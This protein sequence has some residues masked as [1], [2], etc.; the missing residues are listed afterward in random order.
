MRTNILKKN[1][2]EGKTSLGLSISS[3]AHPDLAEY[4]GYQGWD[5]VWM[6]VEHGSYTLADIA[7]IARACDVAGI[8]SMAR[9]GKP[10]SSS[11]LL[12]F[13]ETG[14]QGIV[15]PHVHSREDV[16]LMIEGAKY[17]PIGKRS[18]GA[19]RAG[20]FGVGMNAADAYQRANEESMTIA[21]VED[22]EGVENVDEIVSVPELD[23]LLVGPGDLA[24]SMG[25]AGKKGDPNVTA[26]VR[27]AEGRAKAAGK[28]TMRL[29]NT[30]E[31][32]AEAAEDGVDIVWTTIRHLVGSAA[33]PWLNSIA[34]RSA[35]AGD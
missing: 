10:N 7:N 3:W 17:H 14:I 18:A 27:H 12:G 8:S 22:M 9:I 32:A 11:D 34:N 2:R 16:E 13:M 21:M 29:V 23:V 31:Q 5:F 6:D 4:L 28:A 26:A 25:L 33:A 35:I 1:I 30:P 15:M 20:N 24:L 19:M